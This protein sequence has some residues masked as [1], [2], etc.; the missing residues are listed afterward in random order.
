MPILTLQQAQ[1]L[2]STN[3]ACLCLDLGEKKIGVAKSDAGWHLASPLKVL[4]SKK[5]SVLAEEIFKLIEINEIIL[6]VIGLPL[7]A[8]GTEGKRTQSVRQFGRNLTKIKDIDIYFQDERYS[9]VASHKSLDGLN[10]TEGMKKKFIDKL[11]AA[12]ILQGFLG[13]QRP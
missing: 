10:L 6:L 4:D 2:K 11:A 5:F 3:R 1:E 12:Q 13:L 8:D 9:T 7:N